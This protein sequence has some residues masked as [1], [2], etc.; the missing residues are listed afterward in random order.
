MNA[1]ETD[2]SER[3]KAAGVKENGL[4]SGVA[5]W[6]V[7]GRD[8][9]CYRNAC[10]NIGA[11]EQWNILC[12]LAQPIT[13]CFLAKS[14]SAPTLAKMCRHIIFDLIVFE[15]MGVSSS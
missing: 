4:S 2:A 15:I 9:A 13:H 6:K 12:V 7:G 11:K 5:T 10:M 3:Q 14:A 8:Y 1:K